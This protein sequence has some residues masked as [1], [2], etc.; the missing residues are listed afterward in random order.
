[1]QVTVNAA[2]PDD[3]VTVNT[4]TGAVG[5]TAAE[6]VKVRDAE[7]VPPVFEA[8]SVTLKTP[9]ED[10]MPDIEPVAVLTNNPDGSPMAL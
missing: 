9:V 10:G 5:A 4:A 8:V 2:G 3:G 1:L 6:I 7:P